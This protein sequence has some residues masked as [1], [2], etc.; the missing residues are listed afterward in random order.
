M[1]R[2]CFITIFC[3]LFNFMYS[4]NTQDSIIISDTIKKTETI[5]AYNYSH[6]THYNVI[7]FQNAGSLFVFNNKNHV[8]SISYFVPEVFCNFSRN[9]SLFSISAR[10]SQFEERVKYSTNHQIVTEFQR[11]VI[12]TI[13]WYQEVIGIDTS[14]HYITKE[15]QIQDFDTNYVDSIRNIKQNLQCIS[16][17]LRYGYYFTKGYWRYNLGLGVIPTI[18]INTSNINN[19]LVLKESNQYNIFLEPTFEVTYW[20]FDKIFFHSKMA[21]SQALMPYKSVNRKNVYVSNLYIGI[22]LSYLFYD[23]MWE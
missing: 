13:S 21:Y 10:Y 14:I 23:K 22:G 8:S 6:P 7:G 9:T 11:T 19:N 4:Q 5:I 2:F 18:L 20:V 16:L 12:D 17:P 15:K 3:L 1:Q